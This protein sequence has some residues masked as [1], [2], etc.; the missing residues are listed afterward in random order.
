M[1]KGPNNGVL[2]LYLKKEFDSV[3]HQIMLKT[4]ELYD[5]QG[6]ILALFKSYLIA[7][8]QMFLANGSNSSPQ[9]IN[10]GVPQGS[11]LGPLLFLLFINDLP[12]CLKHSTPGLF[13]DD[14]NINVAGRDVTVRENLLNEDLEQVRK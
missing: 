3:D 14:T 5:V 12:N 9:H 7:R 2:Y 8:S 1:D 6:T 4:Q 11:I 10:Y 13:A